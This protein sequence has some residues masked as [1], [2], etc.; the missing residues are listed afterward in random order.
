MK[1]TAVFWSAKV[2]KSLCRIPWAIQKKFSA[3]LRTVEQLGLPEVRKRPGYH[4]EPLLGT[5]LGQRSIRLNRA[6]RAIY[7]EWSEVEIEV[8]EVMKH[9]Y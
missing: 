2:D 7:I 5:R 6:Y 9:D 8:I 4:D 1:K 3:W